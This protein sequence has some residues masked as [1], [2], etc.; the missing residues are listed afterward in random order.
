[1]YFIEWIRFVTFEYMKR[2]TFEL[3]LSECP[4]CDILNNSILFL[5]NKA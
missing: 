1:M 2:L 5:G 3:G 4:D